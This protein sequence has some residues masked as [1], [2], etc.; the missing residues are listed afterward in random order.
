VHVFI[1]PF[2][3]D[4]Q[5]ALNLGLEDQIAALEWLQANIHFFEG[6]KNKVASSQPVIGILCGPMLSGS[7]IG[8]CLWRKC[9]SHHDWGVA[10][11]SPI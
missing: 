3:A 9:W 5:R 10:S 2:L 6:D 11:Q 4:D 1:H 7:S 8:D